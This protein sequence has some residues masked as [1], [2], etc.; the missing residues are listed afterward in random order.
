MSDS[1]S[2]WHEMNEETQVW[3]AKSK[4]VVSEGHKRQAYNIL[5]EYPE[6]AIF[7]AARIIRV[8]KQR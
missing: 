6:E 8:G 7:E 4:A 1:V 2:K 3:H 5:V